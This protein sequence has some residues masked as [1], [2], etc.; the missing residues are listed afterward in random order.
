M[1]TVMIT[2]LV[3]R[4]VHAFSLFYRRRRRRWGYRALVGRDPS[5]ED[6]VS[7]TRPLDTI[8]DLPVITAMHALA[9]LALGSL[10]SSN[11]L[12]C[13]CDSYNK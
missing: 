7:S 12:T 3:L 9:R 4:P 5:F 11:G 2:T 10:I 1:I 13:I 8:K 6:E